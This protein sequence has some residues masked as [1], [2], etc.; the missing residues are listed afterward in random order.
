MSPASTPEGTPGP[1]LWGSVPR[2][3]EVRGSVPSGAR[4][5]GRTACVDSG[6]GES[7]E[8]RNREPNP[9]IGTGSAIRVSEPDPPIRSGNPVTATIT[10]AP[11]HRTDTDRPP[12]GDTVP[13]RGKSIQRTI[14]THTATWHG[15]VEA[16]RASEPYGVSVNEVLERLMCEYVAD[17]EE[18]AMG[19]NDATGGRELPE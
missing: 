12:N 13:A 17:A 5:A 4:E 6:L 16:V 14:R 10:T 7:G 3:G 19:G 1:S 2:T 11:P 15:F 9:S 8:Y 18:Q